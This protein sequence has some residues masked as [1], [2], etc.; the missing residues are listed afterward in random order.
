MPFSSLIIDLIRANWGTRMV[1]LLVMGK[2][3]S[4]KGYWDRKSAI[5]V[6]RRIPWGPSDVS[7]KDSHHNVLSFVYDYGVVTHLLI[8]SVI[9]TM[10]LIT[11]ATWYS[12]WVVR[13]DVCVVIGLQR[14]RRR[15]GWSLPFDRCIDALDTHRD[16][17]NCDRQDVTSRQQGRSA[18][19]TVFA[20]GEL[21]GF[22][23]RLKTTLRCHAHCE[24][25]AVSSSSIWALL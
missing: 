18:Q 3:K 19:A 2:F 11:S 8:S 16:I 7:V 15:R 5:K 4:T 21:Y 22:H 10:C 23:Q 13:V 9:S 17:R 14:N 24:V 12:R 25:H 6:V 20:T 1:L